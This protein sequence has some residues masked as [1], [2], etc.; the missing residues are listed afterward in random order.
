MHHAHVDAAQSQLI[1]HLLEPFHLG[2]GTFGAVDP[3]DVIVL[4]VRGPSLKSLFEAATFQGFLDA[5][6]HRVDRSRQVSFVTPFHVA[7]LAFI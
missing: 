7:N 5:L 1:E 4:L 2:F 6:W 3:S